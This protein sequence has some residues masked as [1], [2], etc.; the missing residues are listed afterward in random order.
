M[1]SKLS[2]LI[3]GGL[4]GGL[5]A[6]AGFGLLI[7]PVKTIIG[8]AFVGAVAAVVFRRS[9]AKEAPRDSTESGVF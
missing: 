1:I 9:P 3:L 8:V 6:L 7:A 2:V 4:V 5:M